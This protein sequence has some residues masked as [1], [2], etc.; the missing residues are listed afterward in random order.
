MKI[1]SDVSLPSRTDAVMVPG[2][3]KNPPEKRALPRR[4]PP[5]LRLTRSAYTG[6]GLGGILFGLGA[7][8]CSAGVGRDF[9]VK[10]P[11]RA[12]GLPG[13]G[14]RRA[15]GCALPDCAR[16]CRMAGTTKG[17]RA[18]RTKLTIVPLKTTVGPNCGL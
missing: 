15:Y 11:G 16:D 12:P 5:T 9:G 1:L 10:L 18:S 7:S 3:P 17:V 6:F 2:S 14:E 13:E 4:L 8:L